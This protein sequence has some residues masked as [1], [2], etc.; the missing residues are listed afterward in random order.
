MDVETFMHTSNFKRPRQGDFDDNDDFAD[1]NVGY[2]SLL[3]ATP[4]ELSS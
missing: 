1:H 3:H 2:F 4:V